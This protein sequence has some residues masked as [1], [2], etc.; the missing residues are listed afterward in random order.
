[1]N[2]GALIM[3]N[4]KIF[5]LVL[6]ILLSLNV[7]IISTSVVGSEKNDFD[8]LVDISVTVDF[9]AIRFLEIDGLEP[10]DSQVKSKID[11]FPILNLL[12][13]IFNYKFMTVAAADPGFYLKVFINDDEFVTKGQV[14][15]SLS[16]F[17]TPISTS[18]PKGIVGDTAWDSNYFY[19]KTNDGWKRATLET[20]SVAEK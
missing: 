16:A 7:T 10:S 15:N 5:I 20:W 4:R 8:P 11:S 9:K 18:D 6:T 3:V 17:Y 13:R 2:K 1:M 19:V 12:K 14:K